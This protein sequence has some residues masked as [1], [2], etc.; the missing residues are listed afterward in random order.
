PISG[1][2]GARPPSPF[3]EG[4]MTMRLFV[5]IGLLGTV[6]A[7]G[8]ADAKHKQEHDA[9]KADVVVYGATASGVIAAGAAAGQGKSG[10]FLET[11]KHV[12]GMVSG[13]LGATDTGNR[14]A[15]G[16]YSRE[17]FTR[18][19]DYYV[20]KYGAKSDQ[21]KDCSDGFRFEPHVAELIFNEMLKEA[22]V[23]VVFGRRLAS[24]HRTGGRITGI[25]CDTPGKEGTHRYDGA[26]FIDA[27]Y[28][29]DLM[30]KARVDFKVGREPRQQYDEAL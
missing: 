12:G 30:A 27:G 1:N 16:G 23:R 9:D 22:K 6:V 7:R 28:E 3:G 4:I 5:L 19:R 2:L 8:P 21:V 17:F 14:A 24:V 26:V 18:V 25:T 10:I 20:K 15:I 29:G 13:G 11:G